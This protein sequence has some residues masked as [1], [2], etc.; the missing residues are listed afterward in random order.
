M[1]TN[2]LGL[3]E[4]NFPAEALQAVCVKTVCTIG[5]EQNHSRGKKV[6]EQL[7]LFVEF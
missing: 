6:A 1:N 3:H 2:V 4:H 5:V 7:L